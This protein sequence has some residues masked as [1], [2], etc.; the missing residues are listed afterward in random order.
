MHTIS[1][2]KYLSKIEHAGG[3][4]SVFFPAISYVMKNRA[5]AATINQPSTKANHAWIEPHPPQLVVLGIRLPK[6]LPNQL[7]AW[8]M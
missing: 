5:H 7:L 2:S 8:R 3:G 6:F 1:A 4:V